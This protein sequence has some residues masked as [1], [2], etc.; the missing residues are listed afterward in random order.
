MRGTLVAVA[1]LGVLAGA[2]ALVVLAGKNKSRAAE[3]NPMTAPIT[4]DKGYVPNCTSPF[5]SGFPPCVNLNEVREFCGRPY[6]C[7]NVGDY[8]N[9][10]LYWLEV[11]AN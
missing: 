6:V 11:V 4:A 1:L 9:G 2:G 3:Y 7:R 5:R 10:K 8:P